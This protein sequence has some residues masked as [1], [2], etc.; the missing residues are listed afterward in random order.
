[1]SVEV[2]RLR[3]GEERRERGAGTDGCAMSIDARTFD[4]VPSAATQ[5]LQPSPPSSSFGSSH[6]PV[7]PSTN[8]FFLR[9]SMRAILREKWTVT[10]GCA[11]ARVSSAAD[12]AARE[13]ELIDEACRGS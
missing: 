12:R 10:L 9:Q 7:G 3:R 4:H 1:M 2:S 11:S 6:P 8:A 5:R 13:I